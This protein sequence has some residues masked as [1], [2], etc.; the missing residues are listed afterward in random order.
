[1]TR[2]SALKILPVACVS[3][4]LFTQVA[5]ASCNALTADANRMSDE[6]KAVQSYEK[7]HDDYQ[8]RVLWNAM[9]HSALLGANEFKS[10]DDTTSRLLYSVSFADATA[11]GMHY[12][13]LPWSEGTHNISGALQIIDALPHT[14]AVEKEWN[15][16]HRLYLQTCGMHNAHCARQAY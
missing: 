15:L 10:C 7:A 2:Y 16:V 8:A 4:L 3:L 14:P 5:K 12:G 6:A 11:V 13:M 9:N 1:M